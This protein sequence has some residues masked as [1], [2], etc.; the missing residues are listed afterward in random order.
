M[1]EVKRL[2]PSPEKSEM[3]AFAAGFLWT[4]V[5]LAVVAAATHRYW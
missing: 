3:S 1:F 4:C 5:F 2:P